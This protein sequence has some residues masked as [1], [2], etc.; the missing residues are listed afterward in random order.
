MDR[1]PINL[2]QLQ[3]ANHAELLQDKEED[4][5][6]EQVHWFSGLTT[7]AFYNTWEPVHN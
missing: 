6:E 2:V 1:G 7:L 4:D 5:R 3:E